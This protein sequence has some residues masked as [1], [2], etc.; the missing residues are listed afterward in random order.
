MTTLIHIWEFLHLVW[1]ICPGGEGRIGVVAAWQIAE[2]YYPFN[3]GVWYRY[4]ILRDCLGCGG[5]GQSAQ[6]IPE[7][8]GECGGSG[9][10]PKKVAR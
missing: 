8:C 6:A 7:R 1:R 10:R 3:L 9:R 2:P 5:S 4:H